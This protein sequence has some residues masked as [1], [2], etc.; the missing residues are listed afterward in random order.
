MTIPNGT[1]LGPYEILAPL[2]AGGMGEVYRA[3]DTR[4]DRSVAVKILPAALAS[5]ADLRTRFQREAKTISQLNHPNICTLH[6]VGEN[7]LVMELLE[8][9]TL[10]DRIARGPLPIEQVLR[11][12]AEIARAIDGAHRHGVMHRDLKPGN[13][14]I[15]RSGAK[16]LDFGLA[17]S[18][19]EVSIDRN[20]QTVQRE[21]TA[22][23]TIV[24]TFQYMAPE[25]LEG[26]AVDHRTDIF[27]FGAVLYEMATG[28]RAFDG[29]TKTSLIAA[30]VAAE[31]KPIHELQPLTP[32]SFER[33]VAKCLAKDPDDRWQSA[34]DVAAEL[35]WIAETFA[36]EKAS[37]RKNSARPWMIAS[38]LL[39]VIAIAAIAVAVARRGNADPP[40]VLSLAMPPRMFEYYEQAALSPDGN[41]VAFIG[42][43]RNFSALFVRAIDQREPRMLAGT[44]GARQPFWSP[45][46]KALAFFANGKLQRVVVAGGPPQTI[47]DAPVPFGGT[48]AGDVILFAGHLDDP[49]QRVDANGGTPKPVTRFGT[50]EEAHRWPS[51][52]P[53]GDHFL[54]LGD[55][56]RT[57]DHHIRLGSLKDGSS[58]VLT[59]AV[60]NA[61]YARGDVFFVRGGS[62]LAQKL[63]LSA[64]KLTGEPRVVAENVTQVWQ[65]HLF[66]FSVTE[67]GRA[68]YR[69][70]DPK[71]QLVWLDR[72][73]KT[74]ATLGEPRRYETVRISPDQKRIAFGQ[75][76]ADNR[77]E[78]IWLLDTARGL[79]SRFTFDP[80]A[81]GGPV[82]S[83][84]GAR[85]AFSSMRVAFGEAFAADVSNPSVV[86][87]LTTTGEGTSWP[88]AWSPDGKYL[89]LEKD[90]ST[91][92]DLIL[93]SVEN[94][95]MK[96]YIATPFGESAAAFSPDGSRLAYVSD[97][98]GRAEVYV[99]KF[100]S[101]M[102][103]RQVSTGGASSPRWRG[104]GKELFFMVEDELRSIDM[105]DENAT[106]QPLFR[107]TFATYDVSADGQRI[108]VPQPVEDI[109]TI[110]LTF[111][112]GA[113]S[114]APEK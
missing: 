65:N 27:A 5:N 113:L 69:T 24:G 75:R 76:D 13:V 39:A 74:I 89:L 87:R 18:T 7:F 20:A 56:P 36:R 112:S 2:G 45:D 79:T 92:S 105:T 9:E 111:V 57:E 71:E 38:A 50:G 88:S 80:A 1:R 86:Q 60:T 106:A 54:F 46:G 99:E 53:D 70:V 72:G 23:G 19:G 110:P 94:G 107:G 95:T 82:W 59:Q 77:G 55:A 17:K 49:I 48:W 64:K 34:S 108:L 3:R 114:S 109:T 85:I 29:K 30:I 31:P 25:Q 26:A 78:D 97:E 16:V 52:L 58:V 28:R 41:T 61:R 15:T 22:E 84:D 21:L 63:D 98:S 6:D 101:R 73:G 91:N 44:E 66:E 100:P 43:R 35:T 10:A 104:D 83:P 102:D 12:G 47:C 96:P 51:F 37:P 62:L 67:N 11:L 93:Y 33:L 103:R 8:G 81:D 4:L 90:L 68:L 42:F 32:P 14:M 40:M